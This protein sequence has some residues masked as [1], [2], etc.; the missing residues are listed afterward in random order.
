MLEEVGG[1]A[2]GQ[3]ALC[4]LVEQMTGGD[5][6]GKPRSRLSKSLTTSPASHRKL[7]WNCGMRNRARSRLGNQILRRAVLYPRPDQC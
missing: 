2:R 5:L 1:V 3:H 7:R 4:F 6:S